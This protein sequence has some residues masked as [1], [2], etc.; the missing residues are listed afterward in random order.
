MCAGS[1]SSTHASRASSG[2]CAIP[3]S[4]AAL[5]WASVL[6]DPRSNHR[7]QLT[8]GRAGG[9]GRELLQEPSSGSKRGCAIRS[10]HRGRGLTFTRRQERRDLAGREYGE[11]PERLNG[12]VSKT[13]VS[14]RAPGVQIPPSPPSTARAA[15][16]IP[17]TRVDRGRRYYQ[18]ASSGEVSE[19][20]KEH[21]WKACV[22][23]T[24]P[25]VRIP[26]SPPD[27]APIRDRAVS[28]GAFRARCATRGGRGSG[29]GPA[30]G[31]GSNRVRP[32][33]EQ[34]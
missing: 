18:P 13:S 34:P 7:A 1:A 2:A 25:R 17:R 15:Q 22:S 33:T 24:A 20:L 28:G 3:S 27:L 26:P 4:G 23:A 11:V 12:L 9:R 31:A 10:R 30:M 8:R 29:F 32:G 14:S 5:P 19:W 16:A 6:S 21:A